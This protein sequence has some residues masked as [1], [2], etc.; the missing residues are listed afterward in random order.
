MALTLP[1]VRVENGRMTMAELEALDRAE[2]ARIRAKVISNLERAIVIA[3]ERHARVDKLE[4]HL[5]QLLVQQ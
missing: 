2:R 4:E 1:R 5:A 3:R